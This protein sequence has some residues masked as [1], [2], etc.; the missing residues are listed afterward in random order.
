MLTIS[1]FDVARLRLRSVTPPAAIS[2][3]WNA[4]VMAFTDVAIESAFVVS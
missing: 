2:S 3:R 1:A 4:V